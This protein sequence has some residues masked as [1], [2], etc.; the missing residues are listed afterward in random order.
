MAAVPLPAEIHRAVVDA[1]ARLDPRQVL[2]SANK[3]HLQFG[4]RVGDAVSRIID[5]VEGALGEIERGKAEL[6]S[7]DGNISEDKR[8]V[9]QL[10]FVM[11]VVRLALRQ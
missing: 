8:H 9:H 4:T 11:S 7:T 5:A 10:G 1:L 6:I 3:S 2:G